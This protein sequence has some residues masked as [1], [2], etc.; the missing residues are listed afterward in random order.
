MLAV[1]AHV[2]GDHTDEASLASLASVRDIRRALE[3]LL[4]YRLVQE[5]LRARY[6][7]HA[8]VRYAIARRTTP[9][10]QRLYDHYVAMLERDPARLRLEQT[11]LFTA[12]DHAHRQNDMN[13]LLRIDRLLATLDE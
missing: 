7:L 11:H 9:D 6:A 4:E 10:P 8:V 3:P 12:M 2:E 5:P 1:L 13:G